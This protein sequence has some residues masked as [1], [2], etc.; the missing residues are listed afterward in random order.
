MAD[1]P[2]PDDYTQED[3]WDDDRGLEQC[4][5]CG[6]GYSPNG[7]Y[8]GPVWDKAG[9]RFETYFDTPAGA[10]TF[11]KDCWPTLNKNRKRADNASLGDFA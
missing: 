5:C 3:T 1:P 7:L 2:T 10:V 8:I 11:C 6:T 9:R 4:A